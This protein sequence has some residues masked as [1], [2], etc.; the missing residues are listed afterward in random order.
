MFRQY[1]SCGTLNV[2]NIVGS[3]MPPYHGGK[4]IFVDPTWGSDGNSGKTPKKALASLEAAW[5]ECRY[6]LDVGKT[7]GYNDT[8]YLIGGL[9]ANVLSA[10]FTW[11]KSH[12][13]LVGV[14]GDQVNNSRCRITMSNT[15]RSGAMFTISG[16]GCQFHNIYWNDDSNASVS[17][18][19]PGAVKVSGDRNYFKRCHISGIV[20][21]T[22]DVAN[23]FSLKL[24]GADEMLFEDCMIGN[25]TID[26]GSAENSAL[27]WS[28]G[29]KVVFKGCTLYARIE[30]AS[31]H[32]LVW[33]PND[34][35]EVNGG[36]LSWNKFDDCDFIYTST[37]QAYTPTEFFKVAAQAA[38]TKN[39]ILLRNCAG[40]SGKVGQACD[41]DSN[42]RGLIWTAMPAAA[43][44]GDGGYGIAV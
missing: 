33:V 11:D 3:G 25:D 4:K 32:A 27:M 21:S 14:G 43:A 40:V 39:L 9:T 15:T 34:G 30:H 6:D 36:A 2:D 16:N 23:A 20:H 18:V 26:K 5:D 28:N 7:K 17:A 29:S 12:T 37:N 42:D 31:N 19:A 44:N 41:W 22:L 38:A 8:I 35:Q 10:A 1:L 24:D 13:H